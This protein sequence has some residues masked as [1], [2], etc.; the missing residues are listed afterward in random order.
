MRIVTA[1]ASILA[2]TASMAENRVDIVRPDAPALA[3]FGD[4]KIG[5]TTMTFTN[6]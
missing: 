2:A 1:A 4:H 5:V 6:P 3:A